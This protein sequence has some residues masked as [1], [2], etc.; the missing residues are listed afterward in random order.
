M[1]PFGNDH[2]VMFYVEYKDPWYLQE[3]IPFIFLGALGVSIMNLVPTGT[4]SIYIPRSSRGEYDMIPTDPSKCINDQ[5][6]RSDTEFCR[7]SLLKFSDQIVRQNP[8]RSE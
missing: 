7:T 4:Y 8:P 1:N 6:L 5:T 2:L 3:L